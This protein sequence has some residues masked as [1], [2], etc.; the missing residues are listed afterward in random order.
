MA[1]KMD[2]D[3]ML[4]KGHIEPL[5][6]YGQKSTAR[7]YEDVITAWVEGKFTNILDP[8]KKGWSQLVERK[9]KDDNWARSSETAA[10]STI[11]G[12]KTFAQLMYDNPLWGLLPKVNWINAKSGWRVV[13]S[14]IATLVSGVAENGALPATLHPTLNEVECRPK[15][16]ATTWS[17]YDL[18]SIESKLGNDAI[19]IEEFGRQYYSDAHARGI[20]DKLGDTVNTV[21]T[22]DIESYDRI[23]SSYA[24]IQMS[25]NPPAANDA[26]LAG[27]LVDGST[28]DRDAGT[29]WTD[30]Q[31][32]HN[33]GTDRT[34]ELAHMNELARKCR[35]AGLK[36]GVWITNFEVREKLD[37]LIEPK[38]RFVGASRKVYSVNGVQTP[39][40]EDTGFEVATYLGMP[41][42]ET[43]DLDDTAHEGSRIWLVDLDHLHIR[44]ALPT[45]YLTSEDADKFALGY[46]RTESMY[47]T[48][49][50]LVATKFYSMGKIRDIDIS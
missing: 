26:D 20:N 50:E 37:A 46:F 12:S 30:A 4:P 41:I 10:W 43:A 27:Y 17:V 7:F 5:N 16:M 40:G 31:L 38:Q 18:L 35:K 23:T 15:I 33:D 44:V 49:A 32:V 36:N 22:N 42:I 9:V 3:A 39:A 21:H 8:R 24:E 34:L 1:V 19:P 25:D 11:Y 47:V 2:I 14:D 45:L 28:H 29:G 48:M 6:G 13:S